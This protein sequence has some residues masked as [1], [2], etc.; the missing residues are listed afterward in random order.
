MTNEHNLWLWF[1]AGMIPYDIKQQ[2]LSDDSR[3]LQAHA[4]FWSAEI[5]LNCK[6]QTQWTIRIPL[7][8]RLRNALLA[9]ARRLW[10]DEQQ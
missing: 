8:L 4:F 5:C 2:F 1:V 6:R 7:V 9:T 3:W 10:E